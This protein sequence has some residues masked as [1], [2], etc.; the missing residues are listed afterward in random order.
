MANPSEKKKSTGAKSGRAGAKKNI[1]STVR[2]LVE[3]TVEALGYALWDV[4]YVKEGAFF[5]L[6]FTID[7]E[8]GI[9]ITDCEKVHRAIEP[10]IDEADPI[11]NFYYLEVSSPGIERTL[12]TDAHFAWAVGERI[13]A[14]LF[15]A[16]DGKKELCGRL[17]SFAEGMLTLEIGEETVSLP[18]DAVSRATLYYDFDSIPD[19]ENA[20]DTDNQ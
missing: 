2:E 20:D 14:K 4:E 13:V 3:P 10:V 6:R 5:Y 19:E 18:R 11:E 12:R 1:A 8:D 16:V 7:S 17:L 15:T 9:D